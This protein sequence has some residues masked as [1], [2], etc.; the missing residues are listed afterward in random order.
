MLITKMKN[1]ATSIKRYCVQCKSSVAGRM[2][3][4]PLCRKT[5]S[6]HHTACSNGGNILSFALIET[7]F[8]FSLYLK[9]KVIITFFINKKVFQAIEH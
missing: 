6:T 8:M 7:A 4:A 5:Y 1:M 9:T 3:L 2:C